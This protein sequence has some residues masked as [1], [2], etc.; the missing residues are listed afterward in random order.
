[1]SESDKKAYLDFQRRV[2]EMLNVPDTTVS[3]QGDTVRVAC[4]T[5]E[6]ANDLY[7]WLVLLAGARAAVWSGNTSGQ[8]EGRF[9]L[10][11]K[12]EPVVAEDCLKVLG[13]EEGDDILMNLFVWPQ[14]GDKE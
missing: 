7:Q 2:V 10:P 6:A 4:A 3:Q 14:S 5:P 1:M 9:Y 11:G 13:F 8:D 12:A